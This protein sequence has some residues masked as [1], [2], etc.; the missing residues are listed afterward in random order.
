M[1]NTLRTWDQIIASLADNETGEIGAQDI[2]DALFSMQQCWSTMARRNTG[3]Q[4][5]TTTNP[6]KIEMNTGKDGEA[7][8]GAFSNF[9]DR[10]T[11]PANGDGDYKIDFSCGFFFGSSD[12]GTLKLYVNGIN[13][14]SFGNTPVAGS[15]DSQWVNIAGSQVV[16]LTAGDY[17]ELWADGPAGDYDVNEAQLFMTRIN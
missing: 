10:I 5:I 17:V 7:M 8:T 15:A 11:V 2:K 9:T 4:T 16:P 6:T 1:S 12:Q 14:L 13:S 3:A